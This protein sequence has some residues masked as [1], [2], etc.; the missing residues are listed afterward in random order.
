MSTHSVQRKL[1]L[2]L[3][4]QQAS[5]QSILKFWGPGLDPASIVALREFWDVRESMVHCLPSEELRALWARVRQA[6]VRLDKEMQERWSVLEEKWI[7]RMQVE[8]MSKQL[9]SQGLWTRD[10]DL[11]G[12]VG[13][14]GLKESR[15]VFKVLCHTWIKDAEKEWV[16]VEARVRS[17]QDLILRE[18]SG[19]L[20]GDDY[21]RL[22]CLLES[23]FRPGEQL[24]LRQERDALDEVLWNLR[25]AAWRKICS[26]NFA[27]PKDALDALGVVARLGNENIPHSGSLGA[28]IRG[29]QEWLE[30]R[31]KGWL[32]WHKDKWNLY[33]RGLSPGGE[34]Q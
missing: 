23:C 9:A 6:W 17:V 33:L 4:T 21:Q 25:S 19:T 15:N 13:Q 18:W 28:E 24:W 12:F 22:L 1:A 30:Q 7:P 11:W 14:G 26:R 34:R 5:P 3:P 32:R 31:P 8:D 10:G 16:Y 2:D 20:A 27:S 29:M